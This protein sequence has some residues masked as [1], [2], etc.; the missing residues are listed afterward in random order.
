MTITTDVAV[1]ASFMLKE[2]PLTITT[3]GEGS[4]SERVISTKSDYSSGTVVELTAKT[5]GHWLFDHWEG[6][7]NGN[8]N[9]VQITVASAKSVKAVFVPKMYDL[10]VEVEGEGSVSE[11][12][13]ETKSGYY[14]EGTTIELTATP[15]TGWSFDHWEGDL[16]GEDNPKRITVDGQK[17]VK[18]VFTKNEYAF[19][20]TIVGPGVVNEYLVEDTKAALEHG[21]KVL[22]KAYPSEGAVFKGWSGDLT[23]TKPEE[24]VDI[25]DAKNIT[26]TFILDEE[27]FKRPQVDM[28]LPSSMT[29]RLYYGLD[30]S[31]LSYYPTG[32][33]AVD[34]NQD[35]F[36]DVITCEMGRE[37]KDQ[38]HPMNFYLG[39]DFRLDTINS[40]KHLAPICVRKSFTGDFNGDGKIDVCF[41][42]HGNEG[43]PDPRDCPVFLLSNED[44]TFTSKEIK[45][46]FA[47]Y[48]GSA[49]GDF[50]NDG[51]LDVI[52]LNNGD[53]GESCILVNDG[54]GNFTPRYDLL[55]Y[56]WLEPAMYTIE[57]YDLDK[58]GYLDII[59]GG[60]DYEGRLSQELFNNQY[61]DPPFVLW[62]NGKSYADAQIS[63]LESNHITFGDNSDF[64]FY[65][66]NGDGEDEIIIAK[67]ADGFAQE[68][69]LEHDPGCGWRIEI[70]SREGHLF[71]E[72][73]EQYIND[74]E[75]Y[76]LDEPSF[77]W[78]SIEEIEGEVFLLARQGD[79]GTNAR[80]VY[81]LSGGKLF[82]AKDKTGLEPTEQKVY[83]D[84]LCIYS[85]AGPWVS[86]AAENMKGRPCDSAPAGGTYCLEV[87]NSSLWDDVIFFFNYRLKNGVDISTLYEDDY[88]LEFYLKNQDPGLILHFKLNSSWGTYCYVYEADKH[89]TEGNWEKIVV[90]LRKMDDWTGGNYYWNAM[91]NLCVTIC[92]ETE[93][94]FYLDEIRIRKILPE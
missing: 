67:C 76:S 17:F 93:T 72:V 44:N 80:K 89:L 29:K 46:C 71:H 70:F 52:L 66:L 8:T 20:L 26:A 4:V 47:Y 50:D 7:L 39:P 41:V 75:A 94:P 85:E 88:C 86:S 58:D 90:P 19:N 56:Y 13:V 33:I 38:R 11:T 9:P 28:Y 51:D 45:E 69:A 34:Y 92:S 61:N 10:T 36:V 82:S 60:N 5:A 2:Y 21:T 62:G 15:G 48:H 78:I 23:G 27:L 42:G 37:S 16:I 49:A 73:T 91:D 83:N 65:D 32:F 22:L 59:C 64:A 68:G 24:Y 87:S 53:R 12:I 79:N 74:D 3:E 1:T 63:R 84:G 81:K 57:F 30:F 40:G 77:C 25:D 55:N 31:A 6:D 43:F 14:Q 35:G 18:V 54:A